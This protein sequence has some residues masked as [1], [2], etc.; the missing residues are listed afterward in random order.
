LGFLLWLLA[1]WLLGQGVFSGHLDMGWLQ[2]WGL[3]LLTLLPLRLLASRAGGLFSI[4]AGALLKRRLL[5]GALRLD[6]E[7][8]R[9]LGLGRL[10]GCIL[11]SEALEQLAASGGFLALTGLVEWLFAG[12]IL[13]LSQDLG[14]LLALSA[15]GLVGIILAARYL[16]R[17]RAWTEERIRLTDHLVETMVGHR[18]RAVQEPKERQHEGEDLALA[19]YYACCQDRDRAALRLRAVLPRGALLLGMAALAPAFVPSQPVGAGGGPRRRAG[20]LLRLPPHRRR[21]GASVGR[22]GGFPANPPVLA[23]HGPA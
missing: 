2:A 13:A 15:W 16:K 3:L 9:H 23:S 6:P 4:R 21:A 20:G 7:E 1:W 5:A 17:Q 22:M 19:R 10:M 18:T 14:P 11:E 12:G 8:I